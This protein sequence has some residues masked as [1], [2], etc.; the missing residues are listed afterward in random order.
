[1]KLNPHGGRAL[2]WLEEGK[3]GVDLSASINPL[4]PPE[5]V[6]RFWGKLFSYVTFYPPLDPAFVG[7]L[8]GQ[9]YGF[10]QEALLPCNGATQG[11]YLLGRVLPGE[12]VLIV[13]PCF[14][15]YARAFELSGKRVERF[16]LFPEP[17]GDFLAYLE[18]ADIVVFGN[19]GNPLGDTKALRLYFSAR[20]KGFSAIFVV[21]EAFQEFLGEETSLVPC[22]FSDRNLYVVR[23]LTKYFSL[24]GLRGGFIVTHPENI[25]RLVEHLEPWS[26]NSVLVGILRVLAESDLAPFHEATQ[27]WLREEKS[28]LEDAFASFPFLGWYPSRVNFYT[29]W[30][31]KEDS[32]FLAFLEARGI[33]VRNLEDF[34]GLDSRFFRVAVR[35]REENEKFLEAVRAYG[36]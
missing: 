2:E 13:E 31:D 16:S 20:E 35:T 14:T 30:V 5:C 8:L 11:I 25:V 10:P 9:I 26:M 7:R 12:V 4:G 6:R 24:A 1:M 21:D 36:R 28:F 32:E 17:Q 22:V 18:R 23:S 27:R 29:L 3:R 33:F 34:F 19:P 15:E